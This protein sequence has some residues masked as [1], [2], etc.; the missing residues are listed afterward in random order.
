MPDAWLHSSD[1]LVL[2]GPLWANVWSTGAGPMRWVV[3][4]GTYGSVTDDAERAEA[5]AVML[6]DAAQ[7]LRTSGWRQFEA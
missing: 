1:P 7:Q 4:V 6:E 5:V 3:N 2:G